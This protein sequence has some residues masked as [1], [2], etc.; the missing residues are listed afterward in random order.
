MGADQKKGS[1][2][3]EKGKIPETM[4][5]SWEEMQAMLFRILRLTPALLRPSGPDAGLCCG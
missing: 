5:P 2:N 3:R 1:A 4:E